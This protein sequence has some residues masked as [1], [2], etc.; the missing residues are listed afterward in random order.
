MYQIDS[1]KLSRHV[2]R[3][4]IPNLKSKRVKCCASCPFEKVIVEQLPSLDLGPLFKAKRDLLN[5]SSI[6]KSKTSKTGGPQL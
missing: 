6:Q 2:A 1:I 3:L 5:E 4:C